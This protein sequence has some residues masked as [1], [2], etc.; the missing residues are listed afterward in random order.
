[1]NFLKTRK[2]S[3]I[4][5]VLA[6]MIIMGTVVFAVGAG[7]AGTV[8]APE[9]GPEFVH[10]A[11]I[12]AYGGGD[13]G[14]NDA[15]T[16]WKGI[17]NKNFRLYLTSAVDR[18]VI[19]WNSFEDDIT[20]TNVNDSS[21]SFTLKPGLNGPFA[22]G[23]T[24]SYEIGLYDEVLGTLKFMLSEAEGALFVTTTNDDYEYQDNWNW[25]LENKDNRSPA[26]YVVAEKGGVG[27]TG[28]LRHIKGRGNSTWAKPKRPFNL[29]FDKR[30]SFMGMSSSRKF[31]LLAN[32][33]EGTLMR[34]RLLYD[35]ADEL[36]LDFSPDSRFV[37]FYVNGSY[38]GSYQFT[39][40][41][42]VGKNYLIKITDLEGATEKQAQKV[43]GDK[44]YKVWDEYET[45][46]HQVME[47]YNGGEI[48]YYDVPAEYNPADITGGY[49]IEYDTAANASGDWNKFKTA[50]GQWVTLKGPEATTEAQMKYI[51]DFV[52]KVE[53]AVYND[54]DTYSDLVD[55]ETVAKTYLI[56]EFS[57][58][59]D[60]GV[61]STYFYKESD[62]VNPKLM[63]GPVWDY[64]CA[65]GNLYATRQ[66]PQGITYNTDN[67]EG[68]FNRF[69]GVPDNM[70]I[71]T[72][73]A[74]LTEYEDYWDAVVNI[75]NDE[76]IDMVAVANGTQAA[77]GDRLKSIAEYEEI[78][79][80][81][82]EMNY[83][84]NPLPFN[85]NNGDFTWIPCAEET[86]TG[87]V[88]WMQDW[89]NARAEW[90]TANIDVE[91][92]TEGKIYFDNSYTNW[93]KVFVYAWNNSGGTNASWPGLPM[94]GVS[95]DIFV[96]TMED[97]DNV[98]FTNGSGAQT[99]DLASQGSGKVFKATGTSWGKFTGEWYDFTPPTTVDI[100]FNNAGNKWSNIYAS[101]WG[102]GASQGW[103]GTKMTLVEGT[104]YKV[105]IPVGCTNIIFN[106]G[107]SG[108]Q[109]ETLVPEGGKTFV[110]NGILLGHDSYGNELYD[111]N[112]K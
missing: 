61:T 106:N 78:L 85:D 2:K 39:E 13:S 29:N 92:P 12:Y 22:I 87:Q 14:S 72:L 75:W 52:A 21:D 32:Y 40:K 97:Y 111:G 35:M 109:T 99:V 36:G 90:L 49:A 81:S 19:L 71:P 5:L 11:T 24:K 102:G 38:K 68:W 23:T 88:A 100:Y 80:K 18:N 98:I 63:G 55:I 76:F 20:I 82:A 101:Y 62:L 103:P 112:W 65:L 30:D 67:P 110:S 89:M 46:E 104:I 64:D 69:I 44:E 9:E 86:F 27:K 59:I 54:L 26:R 6:L 28:I 3:L 45:E 95:G 25:L 91:P 10:D 37:D 51:F 48:Y 66:S 83:T 4:S 15:W 17:G 34:N 50:R 74:K 77:K 33:Q 70:T 56:Q 1:M 47:R 79:T 53:D 57:K 42:E 31:S 8:V 16:S 58:N 94:S 107:G 84:I 43:T 93:S 96:R 73:M 60:G 108:R 105:S 41:V 7:A